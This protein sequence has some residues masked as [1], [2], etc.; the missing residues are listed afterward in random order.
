MKLLIKRLVIWPEDRSLDART[1]DF[2]LDKLNVITGWSATGKSSLVWIVDYVLGSGTCSI[3]VGPIRNLASWYGL[4]VETD[5]GMM[6]IARMKPDGRDTSPHYWVELRYDPAVPLPKRPTANE[7]LETFKK[8]MDTLAGLS[9]LRLSVDEEEGYAGRASFR[10]MAAFNFLPQHIVA[11]PYTLLFKADTTEH[12]KKLANLLPLALGIITNDDLI[13]MHRLNQLEAQARQ[14]QRSLRLR[15][16]AV[17]SWKSSVIG[18]FLRGQELNLLPAG[19]PPADLNAIVDLMRTLV[20]SAGPTVP[21]GGVTAS[22]VDQLDRT[23]EQ[24]Q[25]VDR[26][27][28]SAKRRLRR[29]KSLRAS[30]TDYDEVTADQQARLQGVNWFT[31][32]VTS[33]R[34]VL[35]GTDTDAASA[36]LRDLKEPLDALGSMIAGTRHASPVVDREIADIEQQLLSDEH[37]QLELRELRRA[38]EAEADVERGQSRTLEGVYRFLGSVDQALKMMGDLEGEDGVEEQYRL[39]REKIARLRTELNEDERDRKRSEVHKSISNYIARFIAALEIDGA[40][41]TPELDEQELNLKF[42]HTR[43]SKSDFLWEIGS[44][45]NWMGYHLAAML[46]LHGIFL[47]RLSG[48]PVPTFLFIDQPSQVYFPGE[49]FEEIVEPVGGQPGDDPLG[50]RK[51]G[52]LARTQ[53]IFS[54]LARA[55]KSFKNRLQII[56]LDHADQNAW[57]DQSNVVAPETWRGDTD[58]LIPRKWLPTP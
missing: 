30:I 55:Q 6:M 38:L 58:Y 28:S 52:D 48:N 12:R 19:P 53:K 44:G 2:A 17:E 32:A 43:Q 15:R 22:A 7:R 14:L 10:D 36:F 16:S 46:A 45:E 20:A 18:A 29:L 49:T 42:T 33:E 50:R 34:C 5:L 9:D 35:C 47:A 11:N 40:E 8:R 39:L 4:V 3:P 41:G 27:I 25:T 13:R 54:A 37:R 31:S 1:I 24:E 23:R 56:V 21:N 57:G 26:A 51:L